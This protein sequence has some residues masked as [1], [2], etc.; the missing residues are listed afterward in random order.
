VAL[1]SDQ[2]MPEDDETAEEAIARLKASLLPSFDIGGLFSRNSIAHKWKAPFRSLLLR[3]AV[4]WRL[5]DLLEQAHALHKSE[6]T[7]GSLILIRSALETLATLIYLNQITAAVLDGSLNFHDFGEKTSVLLLGS[8]NE[9]T[10]HKAIN[11]QTVLQK[12]AKRYDFIEKFYADLSECAHPNH[13]GLL[14]GYSRP[15]RENFIENFG[16]HWASMYAK[17]TE[18]KISVVAMMFEHEYNVVWPENFSALE[19][20]IADNDAELEA[21]KN[22]A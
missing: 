8:R 10:V 4:F 16:N 17:T 7:L 12:C 5:T 2:H 11:I 6:H 20:W 22:G 19:A 14:M 13:E 9:T 18:G 21:T 3:E 1:V 15:D